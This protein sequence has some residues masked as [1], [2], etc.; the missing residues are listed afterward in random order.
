MY[1]YKSPE[2][3]T[4]NHRRHP[5][6]PG[7]DGH[8]DMVRRIP[9]CGLGIKGF[10]ARLVTV[11]YG[12]NMVVITIVMNMIIFLVASDL[13]FKVLLSFFLYIF[14]LIIIMLL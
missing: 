1:P 14:F 11:P 10:L 12:V 13:G 5:N 3:G 8:G 6:D 2:E 4:P 7:Q 9:G